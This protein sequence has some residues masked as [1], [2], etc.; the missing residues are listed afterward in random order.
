MADDFMAW[1]DRIFDAGKLGI[2]D[3]KVGATN[4]ARAHFDANFSI[5]GG[6]IG[7]LLHLQR[8]PRSRQHHC[9]HSRV[10]KQEIEPEVLRGKLA[11]V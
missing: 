2:H 1:N 10:S 8:R 11:D 7:T 9:T 3:M 4:P 5:T 6:R